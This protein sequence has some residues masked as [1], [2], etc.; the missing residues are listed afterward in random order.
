MLCEERR[1]EQRREGGYL[2]EAKTGG[3]RKTLKI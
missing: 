1:G 2:A 3:S